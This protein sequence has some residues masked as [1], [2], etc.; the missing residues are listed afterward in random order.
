MKQV[1]DNFS[2][3]SNNYATFR[4]QSPAAIFDFLYEHVPRFGNA[5]DCGT[6]NG[7]VAVKLAERFEHVYGTDISD[8]QLQL[9]PQL[10]NVTYLQERAE[11][12]TMANESIDLVT[13]AQA[14]HWFDF[15]PFYKEV[16]RVAKP[17]AIIA[18]WTYN[19]LRLTPEVNKVIDHLYWDITRQWWDPERK[20]VDDAYTTIPFPFKEIQAPAM[21]ITQHW[22]ADQLIGYL[23]TWS[24]VKN[25]IK[26]QKTDPLQLVADDLRAAFGNNE[27][28]EVNFPLNVRAG[29]VK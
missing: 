28:L 9:A 15:E 27:K 25:Y 19:V 7:Q 8:Q 3:Q 12:T 14:I 29:L 11:A 21:Q 16:S 23:G 26:D 4:P 17:G 6:G 2:S 20:Y 22:N 1:I 18:A 5:W 10:P 13:I 24:G